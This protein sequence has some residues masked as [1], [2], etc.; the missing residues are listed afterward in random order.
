METALGTL[1]WA[2]PQFWDA[3]PYELSCAYI[4][5]CKTNGAGRWRVD[6]K[7]GFSDVE[8]DEHQEIVA[9]LREQYP[10]RTIGETLE[11]P[12]DG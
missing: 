8:V 6:P 9:W 3:T 2:P 10:E 12:V 4:G 7:T 5:W 1:G 11:A